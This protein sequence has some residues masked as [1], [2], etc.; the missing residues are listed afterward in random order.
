M[1]TVF[2]LPDFIPCKKSVKRQ[3]CD[4]L[5]LFIY[6]FSEEIPKK[7]RH[8]EES[9]EN[10]LAWDCLSPSRCCQPHTPV[11]EI[12]YVRPVFCTQTLS[13]LLGLSTKHHSHQQEPQTSLF[14]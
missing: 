4:F 1:C 9:K 12:R 2:H 14:H 6:L 13:Q 3:S 7:N 11:S 5:Y 10:T 8:L